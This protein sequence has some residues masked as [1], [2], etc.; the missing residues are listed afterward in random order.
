MRV[1]QEFT[2]PP[3]SHCVQPL[4]V[5]GNIDLKNLQKLGSMT[6]PSLFTMPK[7]IT[8]NVSISLGA[9]QSHM[10]FFQLT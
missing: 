7:I 5:G 3:L 1:L 8:D 9:L 6:W 4:Y 10:L 2:Q